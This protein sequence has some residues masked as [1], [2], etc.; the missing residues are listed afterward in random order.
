MAHP[1]AVDA[2]EQRVRLLCYQAV[3]YLE[4]VVKEVESLQQFFVVCKKSHTHTQSAE[5]KLG[6]YMYVG[7]SKKKYVNSIGS[8]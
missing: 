7:E 6:V 5:A 2:G 8:E 1:N 3:R 4:L